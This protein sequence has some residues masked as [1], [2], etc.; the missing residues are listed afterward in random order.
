MVSALPMWLI[1]T[2]RRTPTGEC[3]LRSNES[4]NQ[5]S[6]TTPIGYSQRRT[7]PML[8]LVARLHNRRRLRAKLV[9]SGFAA[10][11]VVSAS[12][13]GVRIAI[14]ASPTATA[15]SYLLPVNWVEIIKVSP[16]QKIAVLGNNTG[17]GSV[18]VSELTD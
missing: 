7:L 4:D 13:D 5:C 14:D 15:T 8:R 10:V 11:G 1:A 17:T 2:A 3:R 6:S 12:I 9:I 18:S 16:G